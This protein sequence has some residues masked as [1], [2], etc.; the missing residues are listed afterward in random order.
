MKTIFVGSVALVALMTAPAV[1]AD[2]PVKAPAAAPVAFSWTG[3]YGGINGGWVGERTWA[4]LNPTGAYL[5]A[6]G[7]TAAPNTAGSGLLPADQVV[8]THTNQEDRSSFEVGVQ[9]GCQQQIGAVVFGFEADWQWSGIDRSFDAAFPAFKSANPAFTI[10]THTE[11]VTARL[12][13]FSTYRG[14]LG[15]T[16]I[17][18]LLVYATAGFVIAEINSETSVAFGT[19]PIRPLLNG[20]VHTGSRDK[21]SSGAVVGVG[22]EWAFAPNWSVKGEF[23]YFWLEGLNYQSPLVSAVP[24]FAPGYAWNTNVNLRDAV[25]RV[26]VNYKFDWFPAAPVTTRF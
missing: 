21:I 24:A 25:A 12:D 16:P 5:N 2:M 18:R 3:C 14:R 19:F 15:F 1:A 9:A 11:H 7:P 8:I 26:G 6:V 20:A 10:P 4:D 17:D 23:L 13:W 22:G